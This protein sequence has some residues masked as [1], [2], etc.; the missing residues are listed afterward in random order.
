MLNTRGV[1][2]SHENVRK[3]VIIAMLSG[4]CLFL[5]LTGLGFIPLPLF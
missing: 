3:M 4:I 5:G 1:G 2:K